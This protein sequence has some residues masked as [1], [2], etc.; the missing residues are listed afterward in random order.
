[1]ALKIAYD[2]RFAHRPGGGSVY[3][4]QLIQLLVQNYTDTQWHLFYNP[5]SQPQ[6]DIIQKLQKLPHN[7]AIDLLPVRSPILSVRQHLEFFRC[8]PDADL[9]HY[10]H[11]DA[12]VGL[13]NPPLVLTILDL[14]PLTLPN[15]CSTVKRQ[16]FKR[17]TKYNAQR[18]AIIATISEYSKKDIVEH[19]G[20]PEQ[21]IVV[22]PL[23]FTSDFHPIDNQLHLDLI[24]KKYQLPPEFI[25]YCGNHKPH[26]N[27]TRL[28]TA[29]AQLPEPLKKK[30]PL[31]LTGKPEGPSRRL[32]QLADKLHINQHVSFTGWI[33][34]QDL[35]ALYNLAS[36]FILPSLYEG[37][38]LP[39]L[40]A[41]ACGTPVA[42]SNATAI[43]E[44]IGSAG[45]LFD[46]Y[47]TEQ[48]TS[49]LQTAIEQ[50]INNPQIKQSCL[51]RAAQFSWG[52]TAQITHQIY[53]NTT[54][55]YYSA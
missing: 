42:C 11:F 8:R 24:S 36:L 25:F 3:T 55:N 35:P 12:P 21:K 38:G 37:F 33:D 9:Y 23:G 50:D 17:L 19:L 22:T 20:I 47:N 29:Y 15:Y 13:R 46:P 31:V 45:R 49:V 1:M 52:K 30:F 51:D 5:D 32:S 48:I 28:V 10:T 39:P 4:S 44:V 41:M 16:Y 53:Q 54:Q 34:Q 18:A 6:L 40:E 26:K 27:L 2:L 7:P 14:Y 43:P